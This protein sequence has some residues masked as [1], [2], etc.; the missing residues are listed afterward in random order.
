VELEDRSLVAI[1]R[2]ADGVVTA[3]SRPWR[4]GT[5]TCRRAAASSWSSWTAGSATGATW[6]AD[7]AEIPLLPRTEIA[8]ES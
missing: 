6:L 8:P 5:A 1:D 7:Q 4:T 3:G 2:R